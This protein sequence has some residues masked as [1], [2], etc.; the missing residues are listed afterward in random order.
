MHSDL[1]RRVAAMFGVATLL[2]GCQVGGVNGGASDRAVAASIIVN[3]ASTLRPATHA[4]SGSLYGVTESL[5]AD[6]AGLVTPTHPYVFRNPARGGSGN[7][8]AF[9]AAI[10]TAGR[11]APSGGKISVDLADMLPGWPY[12]WP[13]MSSWLSQVNSFIA[14][15][16]ASGYTNWYGIEPWNEPDG[17]WNSANGDFNSVLWV[18]TYNAIRSSDPGFKIV[19]PCYSYY[20]HTTMSAFLSYAKAHNC[21]PDIISWHELSGIQNVANNLKDYRS[22][23][24]SLGIG[25]LPIS[26]NEYC[27]ADHNLEGQPGSLGEFFGKF[28]RYKVDSAMISW[29]F[30]PSPGRLGS[31]LATNTAKGAG[32]YMMN[33][34]GSMTGSMVNVSVP[35]DASANMDG[36]ACVD[37]SAAYISCVLGGGNSGSVDVAFTNIPA[38]IGSTAAVKIE[39]IDWTSKDTVSS[40][41]TTVSTSNYPV[42]NGQI[43]VSMTGCN[44]SS[45]YRIF[46]TAGTGGTGTSYEAE[47][48][49]LSNG[50]VVQSV[51]AASGGKVVGYLGGAST[52]GTVVISNVNAAAAGT[53]SMTIYYVSSGTRTL[54]VTPNGGSW[55]GVSCS[56]TGNWTSVASVT[57]SVTLNAG[58]NTIKLDNGSG[59]WAPDVDRIVVQ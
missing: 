39:K 6:V 46:I 56:G 24:S 11:I 47:S 36:A 9:G 37:A 15:K 16:K 51:G 13:G 22:L 30:V 32:W 19:G 20:N 57:T 58:N 10:P 59:S 2:A 44:S 49:A 3:L 38:F 53:H 23:E 8:H 54:Y 50:A 48:G 28:E 5:P 42:S 31:L 12:Q 41:P 29:W 27:D 4:A 43:T 14:D 33:W 34:Y 25:P 55:F 17:T 35:N 21:L 18:Q 40:G 52:N 7:Q 45:G 26:I 1:K